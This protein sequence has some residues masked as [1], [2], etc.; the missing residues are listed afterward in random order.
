MISLILLLIN[1]FIPTA[2]AAPPKLQPPQLRLGIHAHGDQPV[3]NPVTHLMF[4]DVVSGAPPYLYAGFKL[5]P[6]DQR[7]N[8]EALLGVGLSPDGL[9][10]VASV[11]LE[12]TSPILY[13]WAD[14]EYAPLNHHNLYGFAT[15]ALPL[16]TW[17]VGVDSENWGNLE[18]AEDST[19]QV[20]WSVGPT[21][22]TK[23]GAHVFLAESLLWTENGP[24]ART[25]FQLF[26]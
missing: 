1:L 12:R 11:R 4:P 25:Y 8:V 18:R 26:L 14:L 10:P 19:H 21:V 16:G 7:W 17:L 24:V 23:L 6:H 15:L 20:Y 2:L 9:T 5:Q 22:G 3:V 13:L